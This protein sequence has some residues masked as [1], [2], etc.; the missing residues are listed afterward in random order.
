MTTAGARIARLRTAISRPYSAPIKKG[1]FILTI[2]VVQSGD[3]LG[4]IARRFGVTTRQLTED[5][6]LE[7]PDRLVPGQSLVI[8]DPQSVCAPPGAPCIDVNGY[9]YPF[10]DRAVF[11]A[12]MPY[13][14]YVSLF[15]YTFT[16]DGSLITLNGGPLIELAKM[17]EV[18]P[19]MVITNISSSG[20]FDSAHLSALFSS[21]SAQERLISGIQAE[22]RSQGYSGV[23]VDFE[24]V[25]AT[26]KERYNN[27]LR[28][29][30]ARLHP[31]GYMVSTAV[32]AKQGPNQPSGLLFDGIDYRAHGEIVDMVL[33]MTYD[34]S[35]MAG[36]P[37]PVS[38]IY[39][40]ERT[41]DYAVTEIPRG[42]LLMGMPNYGY[43]WALPY[44][45][46]QL[47]RSIMLAA[48]VN[49]AASKW[50]P[51][52]FDS[53]AQTPFFNYLDASGVQ[54]VVWFDDARS[55]NAKIKLV[56]RYAIRG[57]GYWQ[58]G[59]MFRPNWLVLSAQYC[60]NKSYFAGR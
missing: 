47:A 54:R 4:G 44:N 51:I 18:K 57:L 7:Y 56:D 5:N 48:A 1:V 27:F 30:T 11:S 40:M 55:I 24:Y 45:P 59:T 12:T 32:P 9:C 21:I 50:S 37:G 3:T 39:M 10:I 35:H 13:L 29:L 60:V 22:L 36:P 23:D 28:R 52:S 34:F 19:L 2:Y 16:T 53:A 58:I 33:L 17:Q 20:N 26:D 25:Y 42:K 14:T 49:L 8:A 43:D 38:P 41:L 46:N 15:S 31:E 6:Q